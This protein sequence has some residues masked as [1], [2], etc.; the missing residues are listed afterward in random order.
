MT[1]MRSPTTFAFSDRSPSGGR[2]SANTSPAEPRNERDYRHRILLVSG[3][4]TER[5][6]WQN[7]L[8]DKG[9]LVS[10]AD[11]GK[12]AL[13]AIEAGG[14]DLVIAA[15]VMA[16]MDGIELVRSVCALTGAPPIIVIARGHSALD[17]AYLRSAALAGAI[18]TYTQPLRG[19]DFLAGVQSALT[20]KRSPWI[21]P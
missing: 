3:K 10:F 21:K 12:E 15:V 19:N 5:A 6:Q 9:F 8:S 1:P 4:S 2:S 11:N 17:H 7:L 16:E 18:S 13:R 14:L 20:L